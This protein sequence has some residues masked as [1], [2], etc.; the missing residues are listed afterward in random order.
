MPPILLGGRSMLWRALAVYAGAFAIVAIVTRAA[1]IAI[2]L[3]DWVFPGALAVMALGLPVILFTAYTHYVSHRMA[4]ATPTF[5]PGGTPSLAPAHGTMAALAVRASPHISW[6]RTTRGGIIAVSVFALL[7]AGYMVL[8]ALGIGPAGSLLASGKLSASDKVIVAAFDVR[9]ADSSLGPTIA[10]AVRTNLSQSRAV[11]LVQTSAI[12]GALQQMKR[13]DTSNV[14]FTTA[15]EIAQ[16]TGAKAVITGSLVPAG[17][18]YI[19][20]ARLVAAES[21][22][23][24]ASYRESAKD[25]GDLIPTVDRVTKQL[26]GK[27]GESLKAVREA[28]RLDQVTTASLGALRSYAAGLRANDIQGDYETAVRLFE[29]AIR[30]DSTFAMA[31]VQLAYSLFTIGGPGRRE[32]ANAA[33]T[34]AF[35]LRD[36]LPERERYNVEGAYYMNAEPDRTKAI[37]ALRRAVELDSSNYDAANSLAVT[38]QDTR[39]AAGAERMFRLALATE[40]AN[41]TLLSNIASLYTETGRHAAF[42]SV[43]AALASAGVPFPTEP[44]RFEELWNRRDYDA[45]ERLARAGADTLPPRAALIAVAVTRGRLR[46]AERRYAQVNE[47]RA[48][49]RG[50]TVSAHEVAFFHA[51]LD[52]ELRGDASRGLATLDAALRAAPPA[53]LPLSKDRSQWLALGYARLGVPAKAREVM[54]QRDA[55]LDALARRQ[56]AVFA[57]RLRGTIA[58]ADGKAD[59]AVVYFRRGDGEADGLP[60]RDCTACTPLFLGFA[61]D[62]GGQA[63]SARTYL[64]RYVEMTGTGRPVV[65]RFWLAPA[66][67]RLGELYENAKDVR[68]ATEY[69]GRFVDLWKNADPELQPR[70]ADARSRIDRLNRANR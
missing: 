7:V 4:T 56:Q 23:E 11:H 61:F 59:S 14:D 44:L 51:M 10:E 13:P 50:D 34:T 15:R 66:L 5:T 33:L 31:H 26:R 6:K 19:V 39:D 46:E 2:G 29:E 45:A 18:G 49:L 12:I 9:G 40:P 47:A 41:G 64:T 16:R 60:T 62:R 52:G 67:F 3:P 28:P 43:M 35:R 17:S 54:N 48:R 58:L 25:A 42:D 70:V 27:I 30:Q 63:D 8:R 57:A 38:L 69:Y 21:G 65:D 32:R 68:H 37:P 36:R 55:R 1:I 20:T 24:L 22:D 53:S